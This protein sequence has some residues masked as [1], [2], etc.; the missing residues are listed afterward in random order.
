MATGIKYILTPE[1]GRERSIDELLEGIDEA[2]VK[3]FRELQYLAAPEQQGNTA[4]KS[5]EA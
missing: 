3:R 1:K 5:Q 4:E 2:T